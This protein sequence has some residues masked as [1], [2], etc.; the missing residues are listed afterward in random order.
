MKRRV[1]SNIASNLF[2]KFASH[3]FHPILQKFINKSY[4]KLMHL[5]MSE[6]KSAGEYATLNELFTRSLEVKRGI[7][8]G[9][10]SPTDSLVTEVGRV[11]QSQAMQIKGMRYDVDA[12]LPE[13]DA[14]SIYGG[15]YVNLYLSPRDYHRYHMPLDLQIKRVVHIPGKLYPVNFFYLKRKKNL[16]IEN[17]RVIVECATKEGRRVFIVLVGALNVGKMTLVFEKRIETNKKREIAIYTYEDLW[18]K[19]G[20]LLGYFKMGS[21]VLLFFEK[22]YCKL[23]I[24]P[25]QKVK[26]GQKIGEINEK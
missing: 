12:L 24:K 13:C 20:E 6:F 21:T 4:V 7:D 22:N 23:L 18:M 15:E 10:V 25:M 26:F 5:D 14:S 17:E 19:K 9:I 2:G 3:R 16:F 1:I 8:N 11:E